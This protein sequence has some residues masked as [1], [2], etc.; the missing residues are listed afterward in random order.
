MV[1]RHVSGDE[2]DAGSLVND[3]GA[4][5]GDHIVIITR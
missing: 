5:R 2:F 3:L 1:N 4:G